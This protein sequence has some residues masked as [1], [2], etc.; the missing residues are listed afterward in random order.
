M[1]KED[2]KWAREFLDNIRACTKVSIDQWNLIVI[3]N[4]AFNQTEKT[5]AWRASFIRVNLCPSKRVSFEQWVKKHEESV[6]AAD[7]FFTARDGLFDA[8]PAVWVHMTVEQRHKVCS[9]LDSISDNWTVENLK[10]VMAL[11]FVK[12]DDVDKLRG[13]HL[14]TKEDPSVFVGPITTSGEESS[15]SPEKKQW[16]LDK[17]YNN[18]VFAPAHLMDE[19]KK[20]KKNRTVAAANLF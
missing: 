14:I 8:M 19:Y 7:R 6:S 10:K 12:L 15:P 4:E 13:C 2:K 11:G 17:N 3:M 9:L 5:N 16:Y 18:F 1:A 20:D